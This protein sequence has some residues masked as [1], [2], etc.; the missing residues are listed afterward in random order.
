[1]SRLIRF[2]ARLT[3]LCILIAPALQADENAA[4]PE[5]KSRKPRAP[6]SQAKPED[7]SVRIRADQAQLDAAGMNIFSGNV[8]LRYGDKTILA[9]KVIYDKSKDKFEASG[10]VRIRDD[11]GD[12]FITPSVRL[13]RQMDT[14][15][16]DSVIF[17]LSGNSAR[18]D[19]KKIIFE[20]RERTLMENARYTTC[21][22]GQDDWFII[23]RNLSLDYGQEVGIA[24]D[25][26]IEFKGVPIF[27]WPY[28]SFPMSD[29]RK[30]GF[31]A[32]RFGNSDKFGFFFAA[33][34]YLNIAPD[35]DAT[36]TPRSLSKRGLQLQNE[37]RY[38]GEDYSGIINYEALS[39]DRVY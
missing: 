9:D 8:E 22:A 12:E 39:H 29:Q 13:E 38:L 14:G 24:R 16:A 20:G 23:A 11:A 19:A 30:S 4:C 2:F 17:S 10:N 33:P 27:Y 34:Y 32:P 3:I 7:Q 37:A 36:I 18:G 15:Y 5:M 1:M 28:L 25:A 26:K 31:L 21:Q 35:F 6:L